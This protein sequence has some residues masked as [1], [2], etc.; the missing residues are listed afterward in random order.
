M[1][2][3]ESITEIQASLHK[4]EIDRKYQA[5]ERCKMIPMKGFA[6]EEQRHEDSEH[7]KRYH[8]LNHLQLHQGIRAAI[9][10]ET[11]AIGGHLTRILWQGQEP[12]TEDYNK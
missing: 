12:R 2:C 8:F 9:A 5:A 3:S 11:N 4:N 1:Y 7:G 6:V 10:Y